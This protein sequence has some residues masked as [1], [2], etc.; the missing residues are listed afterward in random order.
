MN[1]R[2]TSRD[3][4]AKNRR[5]VSGLARLDLVWAILATIEDYEKAIDRYRG[6]APMSMLLEHSFLTKAVCWLLK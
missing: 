3:L 4:I 6:E 1:Q 5:N 2:Q